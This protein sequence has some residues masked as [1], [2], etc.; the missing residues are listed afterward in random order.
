ME[1]FAKT[2]LKAARHAVNVQELGNMGHAWTCLNPMRIIGKPASDGMK[3]MELLLCFTPR[4]PNRNTGKP[5]ND[6]RDN[7]GSILVCD[8]Y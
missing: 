4:L 8:E 5:R 6:I 1:L 7:L 2:K 3:V